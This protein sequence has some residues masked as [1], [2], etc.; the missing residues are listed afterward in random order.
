METSGSIT[1]L[2]RKRRKRLELYLLN[3]DYNTVNYV[4][5]VLSTHLPMC[6]ELQAEQIAMI[7]NNT[8]QCKIYSGFPPHIYQ[9]Y[10]YIQK[11]GLDV[12]LREYKPKRK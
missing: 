8:G 4:I 6:N 11:A 5:D 1:P 7:T 12:Q 2:R 3:D 9:L 10:A